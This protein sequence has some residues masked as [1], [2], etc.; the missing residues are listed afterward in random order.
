MIPTLCSSPT[1]AACC[2]ARICCGFCIGIWSLRFTM[3]SFKSRCVS[4]CF[5]PVHG[6]NRH[7][8]IVCGRPKPTF[9]WYC[10]AA[11]WIPYYSKAQHNFWNESI[12]QKFVCLVRWALLFGVSVGLFGNKLRVYLRHTWQSRNWW[13]ALWVVSACSIFKGWCCWEV[14][15]LYINNGNNYDPWQGWLLVRRRGP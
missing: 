14:C 15:L 11:Y 3:C 13:R 2:E 1:I 8:N 7:E 12:Q 5:R 4:S 10:A 9:S 6:V